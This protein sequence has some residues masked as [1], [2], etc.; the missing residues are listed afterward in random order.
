MVS[1]ETR[2]QEPSAVYITCSTSN[3][4]PLG[5]KAPSGIVRDGAFLKSIHKYNK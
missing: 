1:I 3:S 5:N 4:V 2:N